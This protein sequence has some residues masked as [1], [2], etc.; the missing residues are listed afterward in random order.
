MAEVKTVLGVNTSHDTSVAVIVDGEVSDVFEEE[1]SRR[2]KYWSPHSEVSKTKT[3]DDF[4]LLCIDHKQLHHPDYLA[5]AS[6]DRRE[7]KLHVNNRVF[8]D[9]LLQGEMIKDFSAQQ[10]NLARLEDM[11]QKYPEA[12]KEFEVVTSLANSEHMGEDDL[13]NEAIA[14]QVECEVYDFKQEHHY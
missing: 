11:Q 2:A 1:R 12:I 9:R 7:L 14:N 3:H 13:I 5:F 6:F 4:G 8:K 10:L